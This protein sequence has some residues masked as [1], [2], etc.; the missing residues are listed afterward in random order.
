MHKRD[1]RCIG[2]SSLLIISVFLGE[3]VLKP[4]AEGED[5]GGGIE[6]QKREGM[7]NHLFLTLG[8]RK[9]N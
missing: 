5:E 3:M 9:N 4:P 6:G 7:N 1:G 2:G 8:E